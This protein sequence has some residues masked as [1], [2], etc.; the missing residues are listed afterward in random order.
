MVGADMVINVVCRQC[1]LIVFVFFLPTHNFGLIRLCYLLACLHV[2]VSVGC[3]HPNYA[4]AGYVLIVFCIL[5]MLHFEPLKFTLFRKSKAQLIF[6]VFSVK[7]V[8]F[9]SRTM[10]ELLF[11]ILQQQTLMMRECA[12][13]FHIFGTF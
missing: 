7:F 8:I 1:H 2:Y 5:L 11:Q 4:E 10:F 9:V 3:V 12:K 13:N 6:I